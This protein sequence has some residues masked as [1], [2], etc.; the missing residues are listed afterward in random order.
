MGPE[1][2]CEAQV[3]QDGTNHNLPPKNKKQITILMPT[4]L[5]QD[6]KQTHGKSTQTQP[7]T[8]LFFFLKRDQRT[9]RTRQ[10]YTQR[11]IDLTQNTVDP[12]TTYNRTLHD[13][14]S[15]PGRKK[16]GPI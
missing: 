12:N 11:K 7:T 8:L 9:V 13:L 14:I 3:T 6:P 10:K 4:V 2:L 16:K 1:D 5:D 15:S